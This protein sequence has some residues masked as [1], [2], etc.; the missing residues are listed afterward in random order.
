MRIKEGEFI[1]EVTCVQVREKDIIIN[2]IF[3]YT[4]DDTKKIAE[5]LFAQGYADLSA[6]MKKEY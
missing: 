4:E 3:Y 2:R 1:R 6:Y 5:Q